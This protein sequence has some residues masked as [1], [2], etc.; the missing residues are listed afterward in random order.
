MHRKMIL[1]VRRTIFSYGAT[2]HSPSTPSSFLT[3]IKYIFGTDV[4]WLTFWVVSYNCSEHSR[5][6]ALVAVAVALAAATS[7]N[8]V[9]VL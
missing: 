2:V 6:P 9:L 8:V 4:G 7:S 1:K 3:W 5:R